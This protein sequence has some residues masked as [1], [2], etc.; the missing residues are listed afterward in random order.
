ME[1]NGGKGLSKAEIEMFNLEHI[2]DAPDNKPDLQVI[3]DRERQKA[4]KKR[5]KKLRQR[6]VFR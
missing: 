2:S 4:L 6:M 5:C 1:S 3:L